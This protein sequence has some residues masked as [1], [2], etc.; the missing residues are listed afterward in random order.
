MPP[1]MG[2]LLLLLL[3][4]LTEQHMMYQIILKGLSFQGIQSMILVIQGCPDGRIAAVGQ[5][6]MQVMMSRYLIIV[7]RGPSDIKVGRNCPCRTF[8]SD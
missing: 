6:L 8:W 5:V 7:A 1:L 2:M 3:L 4:L